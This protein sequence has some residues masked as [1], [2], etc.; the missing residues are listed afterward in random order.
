MENRGGRPAGGR[1]SETD[2]SAPVLFAVEDDASTLALLCD[3]A[4]DAGW[5]PRGFTR[6]RDLRATLDEARPSLLIVDD[7]LPDGRGG[8]LARE[9]RADRRMEKVPVLVCTGAPPAR[10][11][12]IGAFAPVVS[13]PFELEEI[14]RFLHAA[15]DRHPGGNQQQAAG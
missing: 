13:K 6:L 9:L 11:A 3:I 14:E 10:Q 2:A 4:R 8:D 7:D 12:E 15:A 5:I 1:R